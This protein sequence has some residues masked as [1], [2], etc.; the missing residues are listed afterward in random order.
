MWVFVQTA[1]LQQVMNYT[2][3]HEQKFVEAVI[4]SS[5]KKIAENL[6]LG[7]KEYEQGQA[8]IA[9]LDKIMQR[10]YE[11]HVIEKILEERFCKMSADYETEQ[12]S[13]L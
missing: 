13:L 8:R 4:R 1:A 12:K 2:K 3:E 10:I 5:E 6:R 7:K 9:T 11:D